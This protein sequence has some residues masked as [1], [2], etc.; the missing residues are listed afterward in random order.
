MMDRHRVLLMSNG[1]LPQ[2]YQRVEY[3]KS[4]GSQYITVNSNFLKN[5]IYTLVCQSDNVS[6]TQVIIGHGAR[7]GY[8]F[9]TTNSQYAIGTNLEFG[10]VQITD[11]VTVNLVYTNDRVSATIGNVTKKLIYVGDSRELTIFGAQGGSAW[12][13][14]SAKIFSLKA[15]GVVDL[16]PCYRKSDGEIGMYDVVSN[17][18]LTNSG[19]GTFTKGQ[20]IY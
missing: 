9:G 16:I 13:Y 19:T 6:S 17:R 20:N 10:N 15:D 18:F 5:V 7:G 12:F 1:E 8:W 14:C 11:K 4:T 2:I 3:I